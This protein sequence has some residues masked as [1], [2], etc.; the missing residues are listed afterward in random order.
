MKWC[1]VILL[2]Q[3]WLVLLLSS[4]PTEEED[5]TEEPNRPRKKQK[6]EQMGLT[7]VSI[8]WLLLLIS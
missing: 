6:T 2:E 3:S 7:R 1:L 5:E 8:S 4:V